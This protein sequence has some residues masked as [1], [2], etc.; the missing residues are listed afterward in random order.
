MSHGQPTMSEL[1]PAR[2]YRVG[3]NKLLRF[4]GDASMPS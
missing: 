4:V 2:R 1:F 3:D